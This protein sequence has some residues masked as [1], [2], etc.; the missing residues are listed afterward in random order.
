[1]SEFSESHHLATRDQADGVAL[2]QRAGLRGLVFPPSPSG[3]TAVVPESPFTSDPSA[4]L[5]E[6]NEGVLLYYVNAEDHGWG[7]AAFEGAELVF[8]AQTEWDFDVEVQGDPAALPAL[9]SALGERL[10]EDRQSALVDHLFPDA[11]VESLFT[12]LQNPGH[13][14]AAVLG[15]DPHEWLSGEPEV[16]DELAEQPGVVRV[17]A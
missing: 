8:E 6:A 12:G 13:H 2:L 14:A 1:V 10:P 4:E 7:L 11:S 15:L 9:W 3:W 17:D 16:L 5:V